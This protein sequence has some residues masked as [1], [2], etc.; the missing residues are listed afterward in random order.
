MKI[1]KFAIVQSFMKI[2]TKRKT[3]NLGSKIPYLGIFRLKFEKIFVMFEISPFEFAKVKT[4]LQKKNFEFGGKN[5]L[6]GY[7]R[8]RIWEH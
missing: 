1:L 3:F 2:H 6:S 7:S 8:D 5:V 4:I